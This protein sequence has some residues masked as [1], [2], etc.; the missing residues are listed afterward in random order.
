[1]RTRSRRLSSAAIGPA[2]ACTSTMA[3]RSTPRAWLRSLS[4]LSIPTGSEG[5]GT[6]VHTERSARGS[7]EGSAARTSSPSRPSSRT[8][9]PPRPESASP[10]TAAA[11]RASSAD[12]ATMTAQSDPLGSG[13]S[14]P[15]SMGGAANSGS[16]GSVVEGVDEGVRGP[17]EVVAQHQVVGGGEPQ[18]VDGGEHVLEPPVA[19]GSRD[20]ERVVPHAKARVPA[21]LGVR[22]GPAP[23]LLEEQAQPFLR[24]AE[25]LLG[26]ERPQLRI[27]RDAEVELVHQ[28]GERLVAT[29]LVIEARRH[30]GIVSA[31]QRPH[32]NR[33]WRG[34]RSARV[35][36][37]SL[38]WSLTR[39]AARA[40]A[41]WDFTVPTL[42]PSVSA[43]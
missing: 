12:R 2:A 8:D 9:A 1:M 39:R 41:V 34:S 31:P 19:L 40:F 42:M 22:R 27:L 15:V 14:V 13:G 7:S 20:L 32:R 4:D 3:R 30:R 11:H 23:V 29:H 35:Q 38:S 33:P 16:D 24:R 5:V 17:V 37:S 26:V 43:V 10:I 28:L 36:P 25:V 18:R 6:S 21:L